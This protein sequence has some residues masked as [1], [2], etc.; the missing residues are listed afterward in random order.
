MRKLLKAL[1]V[2]GATVVSINQASAYS[3]SIYPIAVTGGPEVVTITYS[4]VLGFTLSGLSLAL[5]SPAGPTN[6]LASISGPLQVYTSN[7]GATIAAGSSSISEAFTAP[8]GNYTFS[9]ST[10]AT[11]FV[12]FSLSPVPLPASFPLFAMAVIGLGA[13]GYHISRRPRR[14]E[15]VAA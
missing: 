3:S 5:G 15:Q 11:G 4:S 8:A 10:N 6:V 1:V 9:Y 2:L 7:S 12:N 14:D 13:L